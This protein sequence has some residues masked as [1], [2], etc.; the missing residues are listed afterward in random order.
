M[1]YR[2]PALVPLARSADGPTTEVPVTETPAGRFGFSGSSFGIHPGE[3]P[4]AWLFFVYFLLLATCHYVGK[5]VRISTYVDSLGATHLPY[6][7]LLVALVSFPVLVFYLRLTARFSQ[8]LLIVLFSLTQA[9]SLVL[10]FWLFS[11]NE[12][13]VAIAFYVWTTIAFGVGV[14]QFWS[15]AN[16]V[17]DA[18]QARRLFAFIAAGGLLGAIPGGQIAS[19]AGRFVGTRHA[20][21]VAAGLTLLIIGL[22]RMIER[23][24]PPRARLTSSQ[25][26]LERVQAARGG[27]QILRESRLLILI[28]VLTFMAMAVN[29]MV[30]LQ[31][32]WVIQN[33]TKGLD[34]RTTIF[35][36]F[37]SLMGLVGFLFQIVFT[38]R[39]HRV[40]GVGVGM[41]ILPASVGIASVL[42]LVAFG[43]SPAALLPAAYVLKLSDNSFRHSVE[44]ST[45]ELLFMPVPSALRIRAKAYIDVFV[46]RFSKGVAALGLLLVPLGVLQPKHL[47]WLILLVALAWLWVTTLVRRE[48]VR[49]FREG[50]KSGAEHE[51]A[52]IDLSDVTTVTKLVESLGSSDSRQV[53]HSLEL[54]EAHGEYRLVPPLLLHH[55]N[56]QVRRATLR[57]LTAAHRTDALHLIERTIGDD[58]PRVRSDA[59]QALAALKREDASEFM[60]ARLEDTDPRIR[61]A[62]VASLSA[63]SDSDLK[64]RALAVLSRMLAD[65]DPS[66]RVEA[67]KALEQIPEP[68][69]SR[70]LVQLLYDTDQDVVRH[71]IA[72]VRSRL[73]RDGPN[74]LYIPILI[75]LMGNRRLKHSARE[76]VVA[77]GERAIEALV[78]FMNAEEEQ[79]WVRRAVPK[80]IALIGSPAAAAGLVRS[81][82][83]RDGF[84]RRKIIEALCYLRT[85][86]PNIKIDKRIITRQIRLE[87]QWYLRSLADLWA[88]SSLHHA[89]FDGPI[90]H[91]QA[92]GRVPTLLQQALAERMTTA[93]GNV[94]GLLSLVHPS[95]D[96]EAAHRSLL[97]R[98]PRLR[99]NALEYLDNTLSGS[100]RRDVFAVIDDAPPED[101]LHRA[102]QVFDIAVESAEA[103]LGRL[104]HADP[105]GDP[106]S[107]HLAF[108]A[109]H[110]V[111]A[112]KV[113]RYYPVLSSIAATGED[114]V[115]RETADWVLRQTRMRQS[116]HDGGPRNAEGVTGDFQQGDT[117]M[118]RM[119]HIEK[120]VF[121]QG[122]DLFASCSAEQL[123]QLAAIAS[124]RQFFEGEKIYSRD[125]PP[126]AMYCVVEGSVDLVTPDEGTVVAERGETFGV[127]DILSD[128][129][130]TGNATSRVASSV[131]VI[132][133]EDLFDL[134]SN[135]IEIVRALFQQLTR[136]SGD[137]GRRLL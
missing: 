101:R 8:P 87:A 100:L 62:A 36:N 114:A 129:L 124:D 116:T 35:G 102:D 47:S 67:S 55:E 17:F 94:F 109:I 99:A 59:V 30:D 127:V 58:D 86:Q 137:S 27:L 42:M 38:Q 93:V 77:Y 20:L 122:V 85:R 136:S 54:L 97:S 2:T 95:R 34:Q 110:S 13:V 128:Q 105:G 106:A 32:S 71:A 6:A 53:L 70:E 5:S 44:Q 134:L 29:E 33:A 18:R 121:L 65:G 111:F 104:L 115:L 81:L 133:A 125:E 75:S 39:I 72:A 69:G 84:L 1:T 15:Y 60:A 103:T 45:R 113:N 64:E 118:N 19:L 14:S 23:R 16:H 41:R 43:L 31:F 68:L 112:D 40:L 50:L 25:T 135:N 91:W 126:E 117:A 88:V 37:F 11:L 24:R 66:V 46:Q 10:F 52:S 7:Y 21:L 12:P 80:T 22:V 74:P 73:R 130:R 79:I 90:A 63:G 123:V 9:C 28:A 120:V 96:V 61:S 57:I 132:E 78:L 107:I 83:S 92:S 49:A 56:A 3:S 82:N 4:L 131:L 26:V 98:D 108:A 51:A 89:R 76:A 48:Y 119:A